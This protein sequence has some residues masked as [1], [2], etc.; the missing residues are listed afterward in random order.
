M[1]RGLFTAMLLSFFIP[2]APL[3]AQEVL[4]DPICFNVVNEA[5]YTVFGSFLTAY[6]VNPD[7]IKTRHRSNFRLEAAGT[8]HEKGYP[9]DKAEFCSYGPFLP[10][11]KLDMVIRT[12]VPVFSCKTRI[13][14]GPIIIRGKRKEGPGGGTETSAVCFP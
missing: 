2:C 3:H 5:P 13:D 4:K 8:V 7:G 14:Q 6:Y 9:L 12:L 1:M 10:D 11:R